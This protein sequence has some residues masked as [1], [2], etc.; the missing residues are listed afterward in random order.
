MAN[1]A[2]GSEFEPIKDFWKEGATTGQEGKTKL[3]NKLNLKNL[4][5]IKLRK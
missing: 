1:R 4:E 3:V 5:L 2:P